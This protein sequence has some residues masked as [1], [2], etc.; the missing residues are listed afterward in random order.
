[1]A[2]KSGR[3]DLTTRDGEGLIVF[4]AGRVIYAA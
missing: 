2:E 1:M 4:R 3:L